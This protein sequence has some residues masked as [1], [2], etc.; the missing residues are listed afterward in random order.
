MPT[1]YISSNKIK[2]TVRKVLDNTSSGGSQ[3]QPPTDDHPPGT[4]EYTP[5]SSRRRPSKTDFWKKAIGGVAGL[6][7]VAAVGVGG[8]LFSNN[9]N[10]T[11]TTDTRSQA[12]F[13]QVPT[14]QVLSAEGDSTV[15]YDGSRLAEGTTL[16]RFE[17]TFRVETTPESGSAGDVRTI[18]PVLGVSET[19]QLAQA[20][21]SQ[22][23]QPDPTF[24]PV[25][26]PQP[27][28]SQQV[29]TSLGRIQVIGVSPLFT[30]QAQPPEL[31]N[32]GLY[33]VTVMFEVQDPMIA[34][35]KVAVSGRTA[36]LKFTAPVD[37]QPVSVTVTNTEFRGYLPDAPGVEVLLGQPGS[38]VTPSDPP[39]V[40]TT[41]PSPEILLEL[42]PS[43][44]LG[45]DPVEPDPTF[46]PVMSPQPVASPSLVPAPRVIPEPAEKPIPDGCFFQQLECGQQPCQPILV[47]PAN[48][49]CTP[50]P[51]DCISGGVLRCRLPQPV[52]GWCPPAQPAAD[53]LDQLELIADDGTQLRP[54]TPVQPVQPVELETIES[55]LVVA[56][57]DPRVQA[58]RSEYQ[59]AVS[60]RTAAENR[61]NSLQ[62]QLA[63]QDS[64]IGAV[65]GRVAQYPWLRTQLFVAQLEL[66][67]ALTQEAEAEATLQ[68]VI[69]QLASS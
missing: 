43:P 24:K 26:S 37:R 38:E 2:A 66:R 65:L 18:Q 28:S 22:A 67:R 57:Q 53:S 47:C 25:S 69:Q 21:F 56:N 33:Q 32:P 44:T 61:V 63:A 36:L 54:V 31:L 55:D 41:P 13:G 29:V 60:D 42:E 52:N 7:V 30:Y 39:P 1:E 15:V 17:A 3:F 62:A 68:T 45:T 10:Q 40:M 4:Y 20:D 14:L 12:S 64:G 58:A 8:V 51:A 19:S 11:P 5:R 49:N 35:S 23:V 16:T 46:K 50:I 6:A 9:L 48:T 34:A 27:D 59:A